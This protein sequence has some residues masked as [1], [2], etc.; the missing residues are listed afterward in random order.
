MFVYLDKYLNIF[1]NLQG[2][3]DQIHGIF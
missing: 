3:F 2:F 1:L